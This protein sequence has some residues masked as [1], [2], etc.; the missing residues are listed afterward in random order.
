MRGRIAVVVATIAIVCASGR[1]WAD[2]GADGDADDGEVAGDGGTSESGDTAIP[3][4]DG[5][6]DTPKSDADAGDGDAIHLEAPAPFD[7]CTPSFGYDPCNDLD[8][9]LD[10]DAAINCGGNNDY[11]GPGCGSGNDGS[12][13]G[14]RCDVG[15]ASSGDVFA[16][17]AGIVALYVALRR[18]RR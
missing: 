16:A 4:P 18:R 6:F 5:S 7:S 12:G 1:V 11:G 13:C 8:A 2:A 10:Y 9:S 17:T 14:C 3:Y 15:S